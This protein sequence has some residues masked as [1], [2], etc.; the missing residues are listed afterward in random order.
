MLNEK[1]Q[2]RIKKS[3]AKHLKKGVKVFIFGS[4]AESKNFNDVDIAIMS[5]RKVDELK[6]SLIREDLE[7]STFPYK[8]DII[9]LNKTE[10]KFREKV[11]KGE[12]IWLT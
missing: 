8:V 7:N 10:R 11:L 2:K 9:D 3:I 12:I 6:L 5:K 1:Y 4:A